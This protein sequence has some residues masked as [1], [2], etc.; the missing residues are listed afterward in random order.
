MSIVESLTVSLFCIVLVFLVLS[1]LFALI[2]LLS[3]VLCKISNKKAEI[4]TGKQTTGK[5]FSISGEEENGDG[6]SAGELK[7]INVDEKT[8]AIIMAIVSDES[9]IPLSEL[10]FKSIKAIEES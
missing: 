2:K 1:F 3:K 10:S 5:G 7:L 9:Q 4:S 6:I 8:A